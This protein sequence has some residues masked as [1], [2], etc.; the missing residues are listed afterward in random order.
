MSRLGRME[1]INRGDRDERVILEVNH[2]PRLP[3]RPNCS[4]V[5]YFGGRVDSPR[6]S[7]RRIVL[8][9]PV[10]DDLEYRLIIRFAQLVHPSPGVISRGPG[11][12]GAATFERKTGK[13]R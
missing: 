2:R 5:F 7:E 10:L 13:D 3:V 1:A 6:S 11:E 4:I 8:I 12:E 9:V